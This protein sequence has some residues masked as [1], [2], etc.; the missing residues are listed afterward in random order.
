MTNVWSLVTGKG[1]GQMGLRLDKQLMKSE[2]VVP[3]E[4]CL[5]HNMTDQSVVLNKRAVFQADRVQH[6]I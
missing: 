3:P 4:T 5:H 6:Y 1:N 2:T